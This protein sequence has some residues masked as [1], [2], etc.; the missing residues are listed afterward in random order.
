M[1]WIIDA[2]VLMRNLEHV[3]GLNDSLVNKLFFLV[4]QV[5]NQKLE[6]RP[7]LVRLLEKPAII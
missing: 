2:P 4:R 5:W 1:V 7:E 3:V 6:K